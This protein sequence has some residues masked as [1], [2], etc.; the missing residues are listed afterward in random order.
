MPFTDR[1]DLFGAVHENGINRVVRHI[2]R[3]RPSL[4]NYATPFFH[5][6]VEMFCAKFEVDEKVL[7]AKNPL[8]TEQELLPI[9]GAPVPIGLNFCLQLSEV[10]IDF[11]PGSVFNL[12]PELGK[13]SPQRFALH[14]KGCMGIDCPSRDVI[15]ELL[16]LIER[17]LVSQKQLVIGETK[18]N[19]PGISTHYTPPAT[20]AFNTDREKQHTIPL[21]TR[22]L[23]CFCLELY[24][25]GYFEWGTVPGSQQTWLKTRLQ[26]LEIVDLQPNN[27]ESA[28][29][30]YL[31]TV[32]KLGILPRLIIPLEKMTLDLTKEFQKMGLPLGRTVQLE[33]SAVPADVPNNPAVEDD[34]IK[35]FF[36]LT[37][38]GGA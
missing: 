12:P 21:P 33:P 31:T 28:I 24:A 8:F 11:F 27:M 30:C 15:D 37:V 35:A 18:E 1:S 14:L 9:L 19:V 20:T 32:L 4:F 13:L 10:A 36:K 38:T 6:H 34:Q 2:M 22:E 29:E 26:D 23:I 25:V 16:P 3:Q 5:N 7:K 17:Y